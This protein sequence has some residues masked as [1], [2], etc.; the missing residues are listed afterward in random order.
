M[1]AA[2]SWLVPT[3]H[4][5]QWMVKAIDAG[6]PFPPP[7]V[8]KARLVATVHQQSIARAHSAGV[9]IAMGT[10]CGVGPHGTNLDELGMMTEVGLTPVEALHAATGS[11]AQLLGVD[12]DLGRIAPGMRA[13]LVVVDG[14]PND[15]LTLTDRVRHV[16]LDGVAVDRCGSATVR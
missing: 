7:V 11:A 6:T 13:D 4:A 5:A 12:S 16:Y 9:R 10:D 8:E 1:L 14:S 15:L 3:L 2:G